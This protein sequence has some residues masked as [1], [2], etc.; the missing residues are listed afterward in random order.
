MGDGRV[1]GD[2]EVEAH[3]HGG[4]VGEGVRSAVESLA[5][6]LDREAVGH[7]FDLLGARP[8]L[9]GDQAHARH[10]GERLEIRER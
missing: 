6:R 9:Q 8:L 5:E 4:R 1:G 7:H 3:H 10:A 2:D